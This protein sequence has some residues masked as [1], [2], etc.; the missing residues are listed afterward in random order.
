[1]TLVF[2]SKSKNPD[3][4]Y[5]SNFTDTDG[6][7]IE[8]VCFPTSNS[9][10]E[11]KVFPSIE[12]AFQGYKL[13]ISNAPESIINSLIDST[14]GKEVKRMGSKKFFKENGLVLDISSWT[15]KSMNLM[16]YL[17]RQRLHID[18]KYREIIKNAIDNDIKL[19]HF[20]RS[21]RKSLWG[22]F[23]EKQTGVWVGGNRLGKMLMEE[24]LL[25]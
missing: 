15:S 19:Y 7:K 20:E 23:F 10:L 25:I 12:H 1:M 24:Y 9:V 5:L 18:L 17:V 4:R 22:G 21:G 11:N 13:A 14:D 8:N 2:F 3:A 6:L 16:R